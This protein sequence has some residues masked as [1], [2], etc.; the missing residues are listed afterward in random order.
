MYRREQTPRTKEKISQAMKAKHAQRTPEEK[1]AIAQKQSDTMKRIWAD[2]PP[3]V[4]MNDYLGIEDSED[5]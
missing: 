5:E 1:A 3:H 4:T 2:V